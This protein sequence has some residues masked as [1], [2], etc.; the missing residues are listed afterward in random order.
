[1][2]IISVGQGYESMESWYHYKTEIGTIFGS[3]GVPMNIGKSRDNLNKDEK[4]RCFNY[5]IYGYIVKNC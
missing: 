1:M 4:P 3:I 5:N 2:V